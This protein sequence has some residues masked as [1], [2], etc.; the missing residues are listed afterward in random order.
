MPGSVPGSGNSQM[1]NKIKYYISTLLP[2]VDHVHA[3]K[4]KMNRQSK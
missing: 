3:E 2:T 4:D 1:N